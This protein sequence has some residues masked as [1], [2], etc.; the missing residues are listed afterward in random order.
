MGH[1]ILFDPV[2]RRFS[3]G[4]MDMGGKPEGAFARFGRKGR[5]AAVG[6]GRRIRDSIK[7]HAPTIAALGVVGSAFALSNGRRNGW[8]RTELEQN[9]KKKE[10]GIASSDPEVR[11][12]ASGMAVMPSFKAMVASPG[13]DTSPGIINPYK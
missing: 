13:Y 10:E 4:S 5:D 2:S 12:E 6:I 8:G 7:R 9:K 1:V 11:K 3:V